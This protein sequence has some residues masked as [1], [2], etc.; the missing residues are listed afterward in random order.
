MAISLDVQDLEN[1]PGVTKKV[2]LDTTILVPSGSEGD[3][4]YLISASTSAYA[5]STT[6]TAI[7]SLYIAGGKI[8]WVK[9]SGFKGTN[10][11]FALDST[12]CVLGV[13]LDATISG[14][15][16]GYYNITLDHNNGVLIRGE[17]IAL[18]MQKKLHAL[19]MVAADTGFTLAY[20]NC[21][22]KFANNKFFISSG[23]ISNYFS[24]PSRSSARVGNSPANDC[25]SLLG[26]DQQVTSE[27]LSNI[28]ILEAPLFSNYTTD[29]AT[30]VINMNTGVNIGDALY[31][32]DGT[33]HD[34]FTA[35]NVNTNN[36]T[37]PTSG[38]N[39]YVG[40]KHSYTTANGSYI[41]VL[42]KGDPDNTPDS[43]YSDIDELLRYMAKIMINQID[44][45]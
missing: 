37:V 27:D 16:N 19:S 17:E 43:Y 39:G 11:K 44:F 32:T 38:T 45:S 24:G 26:F 22:V 13:K 15:L 3:E 33:N 42:Q 7:Q 18:D 14:T 2:T 28:T 36:I 30:L 29:T 41:Q 35:L 4:K 10:G 34:Y 12:H 31:I 23:T 6:R 8:G 25:A 9:S 5:N 1:F 21:S 40:I 20:K